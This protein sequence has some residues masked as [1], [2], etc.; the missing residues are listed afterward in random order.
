MLLSVALADVSYEHAGL[1]GR[2][3]PQLCILWEQMS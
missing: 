1:D 2:H 3:N